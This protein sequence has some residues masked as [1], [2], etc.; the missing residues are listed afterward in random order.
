MNFGFSSICLLRISTHSGL[1]AATADMAR[2][3]WGV[4]RDMMIV[5]PLDRWNGKDYDLTSQIVVTIP[6]LT[7]M[8]SDSKKGNPGSKIKRVSTTIVT[9]CITSDEFRDIRIHKHVQIPRPVHR[10]HDPC[11]LQD[12]GKPSLPIPRGSTILTL[13]FPPPHSA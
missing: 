6:D 4:K 13:A 10:L 7:S 12:T 3:R 1:F 11:F 9:R 8:T 5:M 2:R